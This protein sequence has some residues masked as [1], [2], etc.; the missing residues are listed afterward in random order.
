[1]QAACRST[2]PG[3]II[4]SELSSSFYP[5]VAVWGDKVHVVW[6][7]E[8]DGNREIYYKRNPTGNTVVKQSKVTEHKISTRMKAIPNPFCSFTVIAGYEKE[9]F[10][11]FDVSGRY[12]GK[13]LGCRLGLSLP[14]GVYFVEGVFSHNRLLIIKVK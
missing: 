5:S 14:A 2:F 7:D 4:E 13:Q 3:L 6:T 11:I 1:M 10:N 12:L 9:Y 8:R